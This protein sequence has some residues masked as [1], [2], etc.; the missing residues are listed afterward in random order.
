[1]HDGDRRLVDEKKL[2]RR[3]LDLLGRDGL[4]DLGHPLRVILAHKCKDPRIVEEM[5]PRYRD[6]P[7]R[8]WGRG[9]FDAAP[10]DWRPEAEL[11]AAARALAAALA[12]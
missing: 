12:G 2:S 5:V 10:G 9:V 6:T 3:L 7:Q 4:D 11:E 8:L 1:M